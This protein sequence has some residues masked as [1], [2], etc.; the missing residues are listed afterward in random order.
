MN[1]EIKKKIKNL[2]KIKKQ[3]AGRSSNGKISVRHKGGEHKKFLREI[4]WKRNKRD[5]LAKVESIEYDPNR[6]VD[7]ALLLYTDGERRFILR[8]EGLKVGDE[9]IAGN[10]TAIKP[11]NATLLK[12]I[13]VGIPIHNLEITPGKGAQL[14]RSAGNAAF[15]QSK[16]KGRATVKMPSG[17]I[18]VFNSKTM[19]K[20]GQLSNISWNTIKLKKAG[21]SR[22][23]GVRPTVRGVA[24]YPAAHPHGGGE[25]RSSIGLKSPKTPWGKK[26]FGK[27][28]RKRFKYSDK[29]IIKRRK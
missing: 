29:L 21:D 6:N 15:I 18:R 12:N 5:V 22:H 9:V 4:D 19:A 25:G 14:V 26:A 17:E 27:K 23:K 20:I 28:T 24:Q 1:K 8:P 16:E 3:K 2:I 13:P 10:K 11:G 7:L